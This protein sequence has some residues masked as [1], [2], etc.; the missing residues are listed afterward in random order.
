MIIPINL[1]PEPSGSG[2]KFP[3]QL[4]ELGTDEIVLLELQGSFHIEG[5]HTGQLAAKLSLQN[6]RRM[7]KN[8]FIMTRWCLCPSL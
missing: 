8:L 6:V 5:D 2:S 7:N 4:A 1:R 3:P